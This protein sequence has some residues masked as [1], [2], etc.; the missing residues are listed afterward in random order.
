MGFEYSSTNLFVGDS[1][2]STRVLNF[3]STNALF[4]H[5]PGILNEN[6][7]VLQEIYSNNAISYSYITW[8][9]PGVLQYAKRLVN[10]TEQLFNF[11]LTDEEGVQIDL[12]GCNYQFTLMF[13]RRRELLS[14]SNHEHEQTH[15]DQP[16][17]KQKEETQNV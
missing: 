15:E 10:N 9:N 4:I 1:L 16:P 5:A 11:T 13:F 14:I 7:S 17:P 12:N 3:V 8:L 2:T 6:S